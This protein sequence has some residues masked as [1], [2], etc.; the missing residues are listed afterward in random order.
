M[1]FVWSI[2]S[3]RARRGS[4][5]RI[6][7]FVCEHEAARLKRCA[8]PACTMIFYDT[9]R[10]NTRRWC[11]MSICIVGQ[12]CANIADDLLCGPVEGEIAGVKDVDLG[13]RQIVQTG[14]GTAECQG[15]PCWPRR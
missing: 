15:G 10:N 1:A 6:A 12:E 8:D 5:P 3:I 14:L 13:I 11:G 4:S 2:C 7:R 9:G